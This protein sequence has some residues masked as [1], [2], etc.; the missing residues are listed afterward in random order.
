MSRK[1][2]EQKTH[3]K[4]S[5]KY[6]QGINCTRHSFKNN[7][8]ETKQAIETYRRQKPHHFWHGLWQN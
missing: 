7:S 8:K 1:S 5:T 3:L 4:K 2:P 6:C